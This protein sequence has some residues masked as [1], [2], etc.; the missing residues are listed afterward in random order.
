[1]S[2]KLPHVERFRLARQAIAEN[3]RETLQRYPRVVVPAAQASG[4]TSAWSLYTVAIRSGR[5]GLRRHLA[6]AGIESR[7][8]YPSLLSEDRVL[9]TRCRSGELSQARR[10]TTEVLS[11]PIYFGLDAERQAYVTNCI[12]SWCER[13]DAA[14]HA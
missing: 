4:T 2:A 9:S 7:V 12:A 5:D 3:Y 6:E 11:L 13:G 10:A 14:K 1:L 8:Y